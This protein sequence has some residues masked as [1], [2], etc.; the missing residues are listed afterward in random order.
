MTLY[1]ITASSRE[2]DGY[3]WWVV[4]ASFDKAKLEA[5]MAELVEE[6]KKSIELYRKHKDWCVNCT[7]TTEEYTSALIK[8]KESLGLSEDYQFS[9][10]EIGYAIDE[11]EFLE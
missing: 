11:L 5:K 8:F 10:E 7:F 2:Y 3:T 1:A 4:V 9:S 6:N